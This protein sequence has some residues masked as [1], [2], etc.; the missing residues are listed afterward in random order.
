[1][2]NDEL[3]LDTD[4]DV[5]LVMGIVGILTLIILGI[6]SVFT[7]YLNFLYTVKNYNHTTLYL[8]PSFSY[9]LVDFIIFF[10]SIVVLIP[11]IVLIILLFN[12][13]MEK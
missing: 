6:L 11:T 12:D 8:I 4:D 2:I 13:K 3:L 5:V 1:M 10:I 7:N 9:Q